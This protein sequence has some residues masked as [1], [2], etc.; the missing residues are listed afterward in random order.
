MSVRLR[1]WKSREGKMLEAWVIDVKF[2][3]ADGR[4]ERVRK[5]SPVNTR[6]GAEAYERELRHALVAGNYGKES[7]EAPTLA[8]FQGRFLT[9]AITNNKVSTVE[10]KRQILRGHLVPFF[11]RMRLNH[12]GP[13]SIEEFKASKVQEGQKP[14]TINNFLTC[15]RK[16]LDVAVEYEIL[17][18]V[19]RVRWMKAPKAEFDFL[20]FAEA[21]RILGAA[22]GQWRTLLHFAL[23]TGLRRGELLSLKWDDLDLVSGRVLVRRSVWR[24]HYGTPKS[25]RNR[26]VPLHDEIAL[27]MRRHRHLKG[28]FAFSQ[29]DGSPLTVEAMHWNL[30]RICRRAGL[31][32]IG[33]HVLRHTFASH[34][35]MRGVPLKA[36]QELMGHSTIEMTMRYAHLSP[37]VKKDAVQLLQSR[38]TWGAHGALQ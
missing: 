34:L 1:K 25:G 32:E 24:G 7:Q 19:P 37:D 5:A 10:S 18:H 15:L 16:L 33:W 23:S 4:I 35:A 8:E 12:I 27:A 9:Y 38:G 21:D 3:H 11:G 26:E 28:P 20:T 22:E 14:K 17:D 29:E 30:R 13:S 2:V 36:I 31:R 6:R